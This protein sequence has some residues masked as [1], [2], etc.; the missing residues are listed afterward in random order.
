ML[1][2]QSASMP[3]LDTPLLKSLIL[4]MF[5]ALSLEAYDAEV[6]IVERTVSKNID[7]SFPNDENLKPKT[8]DFKVVNYV[9]MGSEA[10]ERWSV[11]TLTNTSSGNRMFD[12]DQLMAL[13]ADGIRQNPLEYR[14]H[15]KGNETQS[16]TVSFGN[17]KFPIL[18]I[19]TS[20]DL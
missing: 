16:I 17:H 9:L 4:L 18:S 8:G 11:V 2:E 14:L 6:L 15:F 13:F 19:Y 10:G 7:L 1:K 5:L 20:S 3:S 12:Q